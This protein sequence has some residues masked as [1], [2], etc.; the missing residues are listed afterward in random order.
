MS[1]EELGESI[2]PV[3]EAI[4]DDVWV[5]PGSLPIRP[6]KPFGSHVPFE[7]LTCA[8]YKYLRSLQGFSETPILTAYS[9]FTV[10]LAV[11]AVYWTRRL[12]EVYGA[13]GIP[14]AGRAS[15]PGVQRGQVRSPK[16]CRRF[17]AFGFRLRYRR[18]A[19]RGKG[20]SK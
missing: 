4:G 5:L 2:H 17:R 3:R 15:A 14:F 7:M 8:S 16:G 10:N 18:P 1:S 13:V 20:L 9:L 11:P 6:R 12:A 19:L